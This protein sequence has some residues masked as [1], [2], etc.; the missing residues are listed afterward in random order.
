MMTM[1]WVS[2]TVP[3]NT[4]SYPSDMR[5]PTDVQDSLVLFHMSF[6]RVTACN[7]VCSTTLI[8]S[9]LDQ[10]GGHCIC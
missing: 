8:L 3:I 4:I 10:V 9:Q 6:S 5:L 2:Y 1:I 7:F